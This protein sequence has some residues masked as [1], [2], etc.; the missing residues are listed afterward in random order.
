MDGPGR[1]YV[2]WN[3]LG[4]EWPICTT[5]FHLSM[6][7]EKSQILWNGGY[8]GLEGGGY[9]ET[10]VRWNSFSY[11]GWISSWNR[12]YNLVTMVNNTVLYTW[13]LLKADLKCFYTQRRIIANK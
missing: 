13:N 3:E 2:K 7:S 4:A 11:A 1:H 12:I 10:L 8:W 9:G 5:Q 6:D